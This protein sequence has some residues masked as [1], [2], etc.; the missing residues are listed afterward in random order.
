MERFKALEREMKTKQ[1]SK[2]GL[3]AREKLDPVEGT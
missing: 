2:E 1:Y 3:Q